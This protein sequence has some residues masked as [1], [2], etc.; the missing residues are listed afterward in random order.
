MAET[1]EEMVEMTERDG[2]TYSG[3]EVGLVPVG[4][5]TRIGM[6]G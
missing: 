4:E 3:M 2:M 5:I 1:I 6:A